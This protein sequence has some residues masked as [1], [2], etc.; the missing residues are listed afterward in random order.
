[1]AK[2]KHELNVVTRTE[3]GKGA[4][5]RL[6]AA[7]NIPAVI[8]GSGEAAKVSISPQWIGKSAVLF[9][10]WWQ[11]RIPVLPQKQRTPH[12]ALRPRHHLQ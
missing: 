3:L 9:F 4:V 11:H 7:G 12:T 6:R 8:Y 5:K 2:Q 10:L 1:M